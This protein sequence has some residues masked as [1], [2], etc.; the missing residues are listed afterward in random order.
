[1]IDP[2]IEENLEKLKESL[3]TE[4]NSL[5]PIIIFDDATKFLTIECPWRLTY[6]Q[7]VLVGFYEYNHEQT[8]QECTKKFENYLIGKRLKDIILKDKIADITLIFEGNLVLD[9]FH[10]SSL[11]E[12][13]QISG[14]NGFLLISLPGG[15]LTYSE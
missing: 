15:R 3:V 2:Q 8:K 7:E 10:T 11:F 13:W 1:M 4:I 12:G 9:L 6:N 5:N 14:E